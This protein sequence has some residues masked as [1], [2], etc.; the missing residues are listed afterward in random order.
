M[1]E[2]PGLS[3]EGKKRCRSPAMKVVG[4]LDRD[5]A[6]RGQAI[7]REI[8]AVSPGLVCDQSRKVC[9][10]CGRGIDAER[11]EHGVGE[12]G[13]FIDRIQ[14]GIQGDTG[15]LLPAVVHAVACIGC[16]IVRIGIEHS[17][18]TNGGPVPQKRSQTHG[19][20]TGNCG[21]GKSSGT[22][23]R[24]RLLGKPLGEERTYL[25]CGGGVSGRLERITVVGQFGDGRWPREAQDR[26]CHGGDLQSPVVGQ[27]LVVVKTVVFGEWQPFAFR[28]AI[29]GGKGVCGLS[30]LM[31]GTKE[32]E[33]VL[34]LPRAHKRNVDSV[35]RTEKKSNPL[36]HG[37]R[38][39]RKTPLHDDLGG[40]EGEARRG[41]VHIK[42]V[43]E[44]TGVVRRGSV[45]V[46]GPSQPLAL[47]GK[48]HAWRNNHAD[49]LAGA[50]IGQCG[51]SPRDR[52]RLGGVACG[53]QCPG[54]QQVRHVAEGA[55]QILRTEGRVGLP[56]SHPV[57]K[58]AFVSLQINILEQR[59]CGTIGPPGRKAG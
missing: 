35:F 27:L 30:E 43:D 57:G 41:D 22:S 16:K 24:P 32:G 53:G 15:G 48:Q 5:C 23:R 25:R 51:A 18:I 33:K 20:G 37:G 6:E 17:H 56:D 34:R 8:Q 45:G 38:D 12:S 28:K 40:K 29:H 36:G 52:K 21:E 42:S 9:S 54:H 50:E 49:G 55:I 47:I 26:I 3:G 11:V 58:V 19:A 44:G 14:P 39:V 13:R 1:V 46:G 31:E 10:L 2:Q 7:D 59:P 4:L